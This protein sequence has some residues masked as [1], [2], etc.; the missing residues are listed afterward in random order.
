MISSPQK[1]RTAR[2]LQ[3]SSNVQDSIIRRGSSRNKAP[4]TVEKIIE[5][6]FNIIAKEGYEALTMRSLATALETGP[7]SLYAHVIN[8]ADLDELL[9]VH[10]CNQI[11][12]P[13]PNYSK[14]RDQIIDVC[15]QLRDQNLRYPGIAK[16]TFAVVPSSLDIFK[17]SEGMLSILLAGKVEP[18][19]ATWTIDALLLYINAYCLE[20]SM[21]EQPSDHFDNVF[22]V[23]KEDLLHRFENLPDGLPNTRRYAK[24]MTSGIGHERFDFTLRLIIN[25]LQPQ[26]EGTYEHSK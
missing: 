15:T 13:K 8:K 5:T 9:I 14:W 20:Q 19:T 2:H 17:I 21:L 22:G 4:I 16:A 24:Q 11:R 26:K 23:S 18:Q 25:S 12:L 3:T 1:R 10:L 6:A 7:A